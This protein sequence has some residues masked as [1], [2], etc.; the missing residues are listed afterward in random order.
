MGPGFE[1]LRVHQKSESTDSLF[2]RTRDSNLAALRL[3]RVSR[4]TWSPTFASIHSARL[5]SCLLRLHSENRPPDAFLSL[6]SVRVHQRKKRKQTRFYFVHPGLEPR[7]F[8]TGS[9][10]AKGRG[11]NLPSAYKTRDGFRKRKS[12]SR[13]IFFR[14][15]NIRRRATKRRLFPSLCGEPFCGR[16]EKIR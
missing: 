6:T 15:N 12:A 7:R 13:F 11:A 1:S 5:A 3:V 4:R 2:L 14:Y 16:A 10:V 9:S 8:A